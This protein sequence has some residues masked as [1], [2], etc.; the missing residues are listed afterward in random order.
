MQRMQPPINPADLI[1]KQKDALILQLFDHIAQLTDRI[2]ELESQH[3][4][5]SRNSSKSPSSDGYGKPKPKNT[6]GKSG[7]P[8]GGHLGHKGQTLDQVDEPDQII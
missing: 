5:N 3:S 1:S 7:N 2:K 8:S 6:R 4:K